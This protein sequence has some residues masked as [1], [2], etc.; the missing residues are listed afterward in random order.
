MHYIETNRLVLRHF[1]EKDVNAL[2]AILSDKEVT[3]FLPMFPLKDTEE[4]RKYLQYIENSIQQAGFYYAVCLKENEVPIGCIHVSGDD[5]HDLGYSIWK[6][7]W[8]KGICS[9]ACRAIIDMLRQREISYITAT[10]D[11]NNPRSGQV[12]QAIGMEYR[13]SYR[14]LWQPKNFWVTFR[15]YQLNLDGHPDRVYKKYWNQSPDHFIE[16]I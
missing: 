3:E 4:T 5:S 8:Y 11:V 6:E 14:E 16:Q 15:M 13:Y 7:F 1:T 2:F 10:H 12:M 9:E